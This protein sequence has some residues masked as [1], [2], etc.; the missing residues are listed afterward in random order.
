MLAVFFADFETSSSY[1]K[2]RIGRPCKYNQILDL[3][4]P[5]NGKY[6]PQK[7]LVL[8][9]NVTMFHIRA[10]FKIMIRI[11]EVLH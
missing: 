1:V 7:S 6:L 4:K 2:G 10:T 3:Y 5:E 11:W 9:Q 8:P